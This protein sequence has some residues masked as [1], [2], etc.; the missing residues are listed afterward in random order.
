M[1]SRAAA[2]LLCYIFACCGL[3]LLWAVVQQA[4]QAGR[5]KVKDGKCPQASEQA[6]K[7]GSERAGEG[8]MDGACTDAAALLRWCASV[9]HSCTCALVLLL[10][11]CA[12]STATVLSCVLLLCCCFPAGI[13]PAAAG[14]GE[15]CGHGRL[16]AHVRAALPQVC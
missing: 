7:G 6:S 13:V 12:S 11:C 16:R 10:C 9:L 3:V 4:G 15:A 14:G 8:G 1:W 5:R 2:A